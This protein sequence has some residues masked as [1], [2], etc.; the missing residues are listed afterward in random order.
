M[1]GSSAAVPALIG[2]QPGV[3]GSVPPCA[4]SQSAGNG[5]EV[6]WIALCWKSTWLGLVWPGAAALPLEISA[7]AWPACGIRAP[8]VGRIE[9]AAAAGTPM[10]LGRLSLASITPQ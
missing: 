5:L 4:A 10:P 7:R 8:N 6:L 1:I 3:L 2:G 9:W